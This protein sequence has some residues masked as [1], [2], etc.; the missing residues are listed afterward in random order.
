MRTYYTNGIATF[1]QVDGGYRALYDD[2]GNYQFG[3]FIADKDFN[4][5]EF[6]LVEFE[7]T[8]FTNQDAYY[9]RGMTEEIGF[10]H[11]ENQA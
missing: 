7:E 3:E 5:E 4:S 1:M 9:Q 11:Q 2:E 10:I 8:D 6:D